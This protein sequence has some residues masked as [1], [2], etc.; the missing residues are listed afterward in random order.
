M[1]VIQRLIEGYR[2]FFQEYFTGKN[3]TYKDLAERGQFP[4]ALIIACSDSRADPSI[5][6]R[7]APGEIFVVRNVANLIPP[8]QLDSKYHGT[9]S[10]LEFGVRNLSVEHIIVLGHS[11]CAGIGALLKADDGEDND[12]FIKPWV[13]IANKARK[14]VLSQGGNLSPEEQAHLC[15]EEAIKISLQNL[16]TFPWIKE[17]VDNGKL[18]LHGWR[19][20]VAT[21]LLYAYEAEKDAFEQITVNEA[22]KLRNAR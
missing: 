21:G 2:E 22:V 17:A 18:K 5:I 7:A 11:R 6:T 16:L 15:E 13:K 8:Y 10:A 12:S 1:G 4:K 9:S 20:D 3:D 19:F 14:K